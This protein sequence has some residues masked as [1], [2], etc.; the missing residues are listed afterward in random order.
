MI[1]PVFCIDAQIDAAVRWQFARLAIS[2]DLKKKPLVSEI[3]INGRIQ[4][5][6]Y[7]GLPN[8]CFSCGLYGHSSLL[9]TRNK[10]TVEED[11]I[12]SSGSGLRNWKG[13]SRD[14][15]EVRSVSGN[16]HFKGF[17]V[18]CVGGQG[19]EIR[20]DNHVA[21]ELNGAGVFEEN[22]VMLLTRN[23]TMV[24]G[25][26]GVTSSIRKVIDA[27]GGKVGVRRRDVSVKGKG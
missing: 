23:E 5:V 1:G 26:K 9:C 17:K 13:K 21:S 20:A 10:S 6:R 12:V 22:S 19:E 7:E 15:S 11:V 16:D 24:K 2:V 18:C 25:K 3:K 14:S 8:I 4:R 27:T